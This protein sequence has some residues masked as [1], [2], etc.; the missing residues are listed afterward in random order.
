MD[1]ERVQ[2]RVQMACEGGGECARLS[3]ECT[4]VG[5]GTRSH[6][7]VRPP[8][9]GGRA[10]R[11]ARGAGECSGVVCKGRSQE[12]LWPQLPTAAPPSV[13]RGLC[14]PLGLLLGCTP[15]L[16]ASQIHQGNPE[17]KRERAQSGTKG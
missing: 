9:A 1:G 7:Y 12:P 5:T 11:I 4:R 3:C 2:E 16:G 8:P 6:R 17:R 10:D 15:T 14:R 13:G